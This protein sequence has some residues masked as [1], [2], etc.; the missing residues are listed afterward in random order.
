[1]HEEMVITERELM[2][3][4]NGIDSARGREGKNAGKVS[5]SKLQPLFGALS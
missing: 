1:M 5:V 3:A 4:K 2:A